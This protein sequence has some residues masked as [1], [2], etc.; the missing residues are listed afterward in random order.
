MKMTTVGRAAALALTVLT[1]ASTTAACTSSAS[2]ARAQGTPATA[3]TSATQAPSTAAATTADTAAPTSAATMPPPAQQAVTAANGTCMMAALGHGT[4]TAVPGSSGAGHTSSDIAFQNTSSTPCTV[5][6]FPAITLR[7][8]SGNALASHV[9]NFST[10]PAVVSVAPGAWIHSEL[11]YSADI[12][13]PGEPTSGACEADAA[14]AAVQI[15]GDAAVATVTLDTPTPVCEQGTI[16][17]KAFAAGQ[18]SPA[19]S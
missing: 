16:E 14:T 12:P 3:A 4:W 2:T 15:P 10:S 5:S 17:A 7:D 6:G 19:G 8:A 9:T 18:A 11:R 13:G 1:A